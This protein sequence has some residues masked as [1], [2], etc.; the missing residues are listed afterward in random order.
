M[1]DLVFLCSFTE[2]GSDNGVSMRDRFQE[3]PYPGQDKIVSYLR[4]NGTAT[5]AQAGPSRDRFTGERIPG[6]RGIVFF[7]DGEYTWLSDL[8]YHVEKYNL[9]LPKEFEEHVLNKMQ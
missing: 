9:R 8:A 1:R 6:E 7:D 4:H 2:Y 3:K 5:A